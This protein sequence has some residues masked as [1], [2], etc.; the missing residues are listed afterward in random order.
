MGGSAV[1]LGLAMVLLTLCLTCTGLTTVA[2]A[3]AFSLTDC[4]DSSSQVRKLANACRS[5]AFFSADRSAE[6]CRRHVL[7][8]LHMCWPLF[9]LFCRPSFPCPVLSVA[10]ELQR[11]FGTIQR[12]SAST[13][14][15]YHLAASSDVLTYIILP[16]GLSTCAVC[17]PW[18]LHPAPHECMS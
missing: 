5:N 1:Y 4:A 11:Q 15:R 2:P 17:G 7:S 16:A 8:T 12:T 10:Q 3:T 18:V 13:T 6:T 9:M 14:C